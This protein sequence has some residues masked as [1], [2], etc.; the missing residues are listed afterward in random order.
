MAQDCDGVSDFRLG[1]NRLRNIPAR[2]EALVDYA[3]G[4]Q[5]K[6]KGNHIENL[7]IFRDPGVS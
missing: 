2:W 6:L 4:E 3:V 5:P 7:S 1:R